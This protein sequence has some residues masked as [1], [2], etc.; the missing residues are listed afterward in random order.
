M[1][2]Q[3]ERE[4]IYFLKRTRKSDFFDST[5]RETIFSD[6]LYPVRNFNTFEILTTVERLILDSLKCEWNFDTLYCGL[7]KNFSF[8]FF[9]VSEFPFPELLQPLVQLYAFQLLA[10]RKSS[11]AN[12]SYTRWEGDFFDAGSLKTT[13][14]NTFNSV[15]NFDTLKILTATKHHSFNSLQRGR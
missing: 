9:S 12:L 15:R 4:F 2:T 7:L 1:E 5:A 10:I 13:Y 6:I 11:S 14:T 3:Y 8:A